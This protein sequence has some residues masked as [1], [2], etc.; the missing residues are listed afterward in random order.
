[1]SGPYPTSVTLS[2]MIFLFL[3]DRAAGPVENIIF[4]N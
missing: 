1:V 2:R 3:F 4:I